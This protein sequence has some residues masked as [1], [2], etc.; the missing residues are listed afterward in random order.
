ME[1]GHCFTDHILPHSRSA[2]RR[3]HQPIKK[4]KT[5][6]KLKTGNLNTNMN[7]VRKQFYPV[8]G[9][10]SCHMLQIYRENLGLAE[11]E[12]PTFVDNLRF[13]F[14]HQIGWMYVRYFFF[15]FAGRESDIQNADWLSPL[16][17]F[18]K[19]PPVLAENKGEE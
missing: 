16:G 3:E 11:G 1:A 7:L 19:L 8:F 6:T 9:A 18:E 4:E 5:D 2:I 12:K 14:Q 13:M 15:N 10:R 17:W